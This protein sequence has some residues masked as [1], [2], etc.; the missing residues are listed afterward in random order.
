MEKK[1][2]T[3]GVLG[4]SGALGSGLSYRL[5]KAG[6]Q[7]IIGSRNRGKASERTVYDKLLTQTP[8][9]WLRPVALPKRLAAKH[10]LFE[11]IR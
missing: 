6:Y 9:G 2:H 10:S 7:V 3:I 8:P 5:G 11:V 4:G 1:I